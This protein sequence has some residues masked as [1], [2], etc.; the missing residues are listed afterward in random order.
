MLEEKNYSE[1]QVLQLTSYEQGSF[2]SCPKNFWKISSQTLSAELFLEH[3]LIQMVTEQQFNDPGY[4]MSQ[5][6]DYILNTNFVTC[7]SMDFII[8]F[9]CEKTDIIISIGL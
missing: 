8:I 6:E 1:T 5:I 4:K 9:M 3:H 2:H 7:C